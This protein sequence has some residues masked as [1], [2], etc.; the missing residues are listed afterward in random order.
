MNALQGLRPI[1]QSSFSAHGQVASELA[2]LAWILFAGGGAILVLVIAATIIALRTRKRAWVATERFIVAAGVVFPV[3]VLTILLFHVYGV[4][5]RLHAGP[6]PEVRVEITGE[7]WWW[8]VRYLDA[9]GTAEFE[10]ANE[11][12]IPVG[13]AVEVTLRSADV[14]HSFWVPSLA[15]KVDMIPGRTNRFV[16]NAA[17]PGVYRGQCA[18]FC[19][20]PH[21]LMALHVVALQG[22]NFHT[23][24]ERQRRPAASTHDLFN[25][26]CAV[27]HTVRGT[28]AMGT[29]GPDLT[30]VASRLF[31]AAGTLANSAANMAGWLAD[32]QHVKPGN[33]MPAMRL[34]AAELKSLSDYMAALQ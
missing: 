25:A 2:Q 24:R 10:T 27:C 3:V 26:R 7:Q 13:K 21:A 33:L 18:E 1:M 17:D 12:R 6:A 23:W 11:V 15:G 14:I 8:R 9:Q 29:R 32:S 4:D 28:Q 16:L 31:I 19:G 5:A 34:D 22:E 30:H 20:G